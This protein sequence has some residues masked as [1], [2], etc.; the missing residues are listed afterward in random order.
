MGLFKKNPFGHILWVKKWLIRILGVLTHRRF[1]GFN[2]LQMI[3]RYQTNRKHYLMNMILFIAFA[4]EFFIRKDQFLGSVLIFNGVINLLAYQQVPRK[5]ASITVILNLFNAL[6]SAI[7]AY[8]Y[9]EISYTILFVLWVAVTAVYLIACIRQI[10]NLVNSKLS[11]R[12][13]KKKFN[14]CLHPVFEFLSN[15]LENSSGPLPH[16]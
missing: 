8:N 9:L 10:Y 14:W 16:H 12:K 11:K 1:R 3:K 7:V 5:I 2:E 4:F 15:N 6:I 13:Q